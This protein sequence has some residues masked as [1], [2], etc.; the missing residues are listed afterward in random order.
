MCSGHADVSVEGVSELGST[1][2]APDVQ[3]WTHFGVSDLSA[4]VSHSS[5][6]PGPQAPA[7]LSASAVPHLPEGSA[8]RLGLVSS[9]LIH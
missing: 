1:A 3:P 7:S 4:R 5:G 6:A 8:P 9:S 2:L